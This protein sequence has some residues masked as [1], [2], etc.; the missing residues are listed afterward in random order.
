MTN[1]PKQIGTAGETAVLRAVL[2]YFPEARRNVQH[3]SRDEGDLF[4]SKDFII[5]VKAGKQVRQV[6]D[7]Q[8]AAWYSQTTTE[9]ANSLARYGILV[10]QRWGV[11]APNAH[12]WWAYIDLADLSELLGGG[13]PSGD[14]MQVQLVRLEL[15]HL[16]DM[17][18]NLGH[19]PQA[20]WQDPT[21]PLL[22]ALP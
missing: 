20:A 1:K 14:D 7:L 13:Y 12:R 22:R 9:A 2:P 16:L 19:A 4:L 17:L 18:G 11:G 21:E 10:L 15:G 3:G 6:G 8:L 5:E